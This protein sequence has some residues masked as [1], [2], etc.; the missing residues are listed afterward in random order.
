MISLRTFIMFGLVY[1]LSFSAM[2]SEPEKVVHFTF[3]TGSQNWT[4]D[5]TDYP[6]NEEQFY[7]LAW[8]WENLPAAQNSAINQSVFA[9][10]IYLSGNNH[11]D[12]L[13]MFVKAPITGLK[14]ETTYAVTLSV[15]FA[16]NVPPGLSGIGGSPGDSVAFKVGAASQEPKKILKK[17]AYFLNVDK[18]NQFQGGKNAVVVGKLANPLVNP[19]NVQYMPQTVSN[20]GSPLSVKSDKT[21]QIWVFAGTDSGFEGASKYYIGEVKVSLQQQPD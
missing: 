20:S 16:S 1:S 6:K 11:S 10:G 18:G 21:G 5:F 3:D 13:F 15:T 19:D 7:E 14:P 17:N 8:G 4:G 9:K 12:D 2:A